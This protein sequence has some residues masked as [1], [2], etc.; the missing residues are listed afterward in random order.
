ML[1]LLFLIYSNRSYQTTD[2]VETVQN[3][4]DHYLSVQVVFGQAADREKEKIEKKSQLIMVII[5][6]L[7][8]I[9][10]YITLVTKSM[11]SSETSSYTLSGNFKGSFKIASTSSSFE[12][13]LKGRYTKQFLLYFFLDQLKKNPTQI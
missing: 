8:I 4:P 11:Q 1:L 5:P 9:F 10:F 12:F 6:S 7:L 13:P 2:A 3:L